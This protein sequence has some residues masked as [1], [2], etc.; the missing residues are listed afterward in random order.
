[1]V[2]HLSVHG[3]C[4]INRGRAC[5]QRDDLALRSEHIY[6]AGA[7]I[8]LQ[9]A[10]EFVGIWGLARPVGQL[11]NPAQVILFAQLLLLVLRILSLTRLVSSVRSRKFTACLT[12]F[13][14]LPVSGD[15]ELSPAVHVPGSNLDFHWLTAGADDRR[16]QAL[17]HVELWHSDVILESARNRLPVCVNRTQSR[18]AVANGAADH[19]HTDQVVNMIKIV[20]AHDHLLVNREV[21]LRPTRHIGVN[22]GTTKV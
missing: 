13:L 5:R 16:M 19:A 1:M 11:L 8:I 14:V 7:Q 15:A 18:I 12:I 6:F 20:A 9:R 22:A 10:Q 17:V 2:T 21:I 3:V 4:K